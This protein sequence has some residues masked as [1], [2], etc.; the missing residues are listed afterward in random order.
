MTIQE[1]IRNDLKTAI[2]ERNSQLTNFLKSI[3]GEFSRQLKKELTDDESIKLLKW[4]YGNAEIMGNIFEMK[5]LEKFLPKQLTDEEIKNI[6]LDII[7][8][9]NITSIKEIGKVMLALKQHSQSVNINN[10]I[11]SKI[12][13][14]IL[15]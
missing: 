7:S 14:D 3:V 9:N 4:M 10:A 1:Q 5:Y 8:V 2:A 12:I 6:L 15:K 13:R 11:A